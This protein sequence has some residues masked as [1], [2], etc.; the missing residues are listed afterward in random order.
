MSTSGSVA[1]AQE[2]LNKFL[3]QPGVVSDLMK[4]A[5]EKTG[6]QR[7]YIA[8]GAIGLVVLWLAFGYGAQLLANLIGYVYPAYMSIKALE[9]GNK[10]DDKQWLTYWVVFAGFAV[11]EFFTDIL[12]GWI[13]FYWLVKCVF[14]VWC[15]APMESNGSTLIYN[16]IMRPAFLKHENKLDNIVNKATAKADDLFDKAKE[17]AAD[18]IKAN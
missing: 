11:I 14:F 18:H 5:E 1:K 9:S 7:L 6:V 15:M 4:I 16:R 10:N 17:M 13:P 8:Y 2:K 3:N 12:V